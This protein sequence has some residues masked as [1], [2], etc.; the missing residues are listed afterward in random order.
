MARFQLSELRDG[1]PE[2]ILD[3]LWGRRCLFVAPTG[4]GKSLCYQSLAAS[5][6]SRGVVLVF[7]PLKAL[8]HEQVQRAHAAGLRA[9]V[10][11]SDLDADTQRGVFER[12]TAGNVDVLFIAPERQGNRLWLDHVGMLEIKGVVIDE[13]HCISQWG[14]DFR[15]WYQRLVRTIMAI[16]RRTPVLAITATA[17]EHVMADVQAQLGPSDVPV[18]VIRLPSY[19]RNLQISCIVVRGFAARLAMLL[20]LARS[21]RGAPGIAYLLT[22]DETE[23]AAQFLRSQGVHAGHYHAGLDAET[24]AAVLRDWSSNTLNVL[25]ATSALGMGMDRAD[26]RWIAHAGLPDSLL[27]YV[28]EIGRAG[29]DEGPARITGIHDPEAQGIYAA[30]LSGS[31]PSPEDYRSVASALRAGH[32]TRTHIVLDKDI[33]EQTVQRILEDFVETGACARTGQGPYVYSWTGADGADVPQGLE[34]ARATRQ[35]FLQE[36]FEYA[37]HPH[38]RASRLSEHMGDGKPAFACGICDRCRTVAPVDLA[39]LV[40]TAKQYLT[41]FCPPIGAARSC[42]AAGVALSR[43]GMGIHGEAVAMAKYSGAP[44]PPAMVDHAIAQLEAPT[45]PYAGVV[46]DAVV[47]VPST[48]SPI[49][50]QLASLLA[51]RLRIPLHKLLKNHP[52]APQKQFRSKQCKRRN[53]DGAF[54]PLAL[55]ARNVLLVDDVVDSG[56]SLRAAGAALQPANVYPL[57]MARAKHQD[58]S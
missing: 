13:A 14:H 21:E 56:E 31:A 19:R 23:M 50:D 28:Q 44:L 36:V 55:P 1:Q 25:C 54:A 6:W 43:Y 51:P 45:G 32:G 49:V 15:P 47:A 7:Q 35:R 4:H 39:A 53:I 9:E 2:V 42:H 34:Q 16:G 29:R 26:V 11:N 52:T 12:M 27:R 58:R 22:Q 3:L 20:H 8:M 40:Q 46:F 24:R 48:T 33:P 18:H 10:V 30:F 41:S 57:V 17:P 5:P 38:C 37:Q